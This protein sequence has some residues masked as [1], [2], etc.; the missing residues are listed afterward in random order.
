MA[1]P[2]GC[3]KEK[4]GKSAIRIGWEIRMENWEK[5]TGGDN[6][7]GER[8]RGVSAREVMDVFNVV[9]YLFFGLVPLSLLSSSA[10]LA[11]LQRP[12]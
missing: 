9:W 12:H 5:R 8:E 1:G 4:G 7:R 6:G 10:H 11:T 3:Q 2:L